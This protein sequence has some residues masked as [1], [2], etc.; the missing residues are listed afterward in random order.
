MT[1]SVSF[2][3]P[4]SSFSTAFRRRSQV[5][6]QRSAKP[7][8]VGSIPTAAFFRINGL[9]AADWLPVNICQLCANSVALA[10]TESDNSIAGHYRNNVPLPV[11]FSGALPYTRPAL[12]RLVKPTTRH[13]H[14][15]DRNDRGRGSPIFKVFLSTP[16]ED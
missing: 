7:L 15:R 13:N 11:A 10:C 12:W 1:S 16:M 9:R 5:V 6:R 2:I 4:H 3:I 14:P 8:F